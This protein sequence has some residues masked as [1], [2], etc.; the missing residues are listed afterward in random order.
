[1]TAT[2]TSSSPTSHAG[3]ITECKKI[4]SMAEADVAAALH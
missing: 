3:G 4:I 2:S 1:L